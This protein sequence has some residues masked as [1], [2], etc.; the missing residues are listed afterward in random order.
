MWE[1]RKWD[2]VIPLWPLTC[3]KGSVHSAVLQSVSLLQLAGHA[4]EVLG[5]AVACGSVMKP[6]WL[7]FVP[8]ASWLFFVD[9]V[10]FLASDYCLLTFLSTSATRTREHSMKS[11]P[12]AN[13]AVVPI[14]PLLTGAGIVKR[15]AHQSATTDDQLGRRTQ[16]QQAVRADVATGALVGKIQVVRWY[17]LVIHFRDED[18]EEFYCVLFG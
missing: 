5:N 17:H 2:G 6:H 3:L 15:S 7:L 10:L 9:S 12:S 11:M 1:P 8:V 14:G 4:L 16:M 13:A 18:D